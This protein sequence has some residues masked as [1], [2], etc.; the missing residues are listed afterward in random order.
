[1]QMKLVYDRINRFSY[2]LKSCYLWNFDFNKVQAS[3]NSNFVPWSYTSISFILSAD[4]SKTS[5]RPDH[6]VQYRTKIML[7]SIFQFIKMNSWVKHRSINSLL[8][9]YTSNRVFFCSADFNHNHLIYRSCYALS[10]ALKQ[11]LSEEKVPFKLSSDFWPK[12]L[13]SQRHN[14]MNLNFIMKAT[15]PAM[16]TFSMD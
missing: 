5:V 12:L 4:L 9:P 13:D 1:M 10:W 15:N 14:K 7:K 16:N 3:I 11:V 8:W 6:P 2:Q